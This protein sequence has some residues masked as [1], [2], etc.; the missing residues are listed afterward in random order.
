MPLPRRQYRP[1]RQRLVA[2]LSGTASADAADAKG[3]DHPVP[4]ALIDLHALRFPSNASPVVEA[5]GYRKWAVTAWLTL[6]VIFAVCFV[7][8]DTSVCL[9]A[10]LART[11]TPLAP[12]LVLRALPAATCA[13]HAFR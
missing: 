13:L 10:A 12:P 5:I 11:A 9:A 6:T 3:D 4:R 7:S 2:F 8:F 1:I